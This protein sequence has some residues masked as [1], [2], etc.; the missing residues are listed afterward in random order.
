MLRAIIFF[1]ITITTGCSVQPI[2]T[3]PPSCGSID[4]GNQSI[5]RFP[6]GE[7]L[8]LPS[9]ADPA[10]PPLQWT[11]PEATAGLLFAD[12]PRFIAQTTDPVVLT[13]RTTGTAITVTPIEPANIPFLNLMYMPSRSMALVNDEVW[14]ANAFSPTIGRVEL[15][16]GEALESIPV[17]PWPTSIDVDPSLE[18]AIVTHAAN[19]TLGIIDTN[20]KQ[21]INS[22][23]V[24][25][26]PGTV[27]V[28]PATSIAYV[29]LETE[30]A[31]A[32]VDL[33]D[34]AVTHRMDAVP[35]PRAMA[36]SA[37]GSTLFVAGHRTGRPDRYPYAEDEE[38]QTD[39]QAI[40][41]AT[42]D[43][44]WTV[45]EAGNIITDLVADEER[46][47]L[48]VSTTV[49]FPERGLVTLDD[50]PFEAHVQAYDIDT[51]EWLHSTVLGPASEGEGYVLGPQALAL[52]GDS[53]WV[54]A[55]DSGLVVELD[56]NALAER[57]RTPISGGPRALLATEDGL[58][59]HA[60]QAMHMYRLSDREITA[61]AAT[62]V[63]PRPPAMA[64]GHLHFI[65]PGNTYGQNFS[66]NSCHYDGRGDTE[67]WRAGP[68]ETWEQSRP[69]MW[70][71]GTAPL[72][73][74]AYV[75]DTRTF[76]VTG[77]TSI[78]S[79]WPTTEMTEELTAFLSSMVPPPKANGWTERDG[80]LSAE[81]KLGQNLFNGKAGC[82]GCHSGA[83]T[84]SNQ[85]FEDGITEGRVSTPVLV[86]AYRH[87]SW[88]KD[89]SARTLED[90]TR[91]AAEWS[92]V[93]N[94]TDSEVEALVRYL[95]E[96]TDRDFFL[97]R[98]E[99]D[100]ERQWVGTEDPIRLTFN[101][102]VW[103]GD[104]AHR[105]FAV[106]DESGSSIPVEVAFNGR[107]V[108]LTPLNPL[109]ADHTYRTVV[110][111]Q[112]ES[113]DQRVLQ[114]PISIDFTTARKPELTFDGEYVMAVDMPAF[115]IENGRF[116]P[117]ITVVA[118]NP[119]KAFQT[120]S[121]SALSF[122]VG[123]ELVWETSAVIAADEFE[124]PPVPVKAGN[125][126]AQGSSVSGTA[127]DLDGDGVIDY[128]SG[129]FIVSGPGF[130]LEDVTWTIE[131]KREIPDCQPG[132]E[133]AV[134]V[135]V[136]MEDEDLVIDWEGDAGALGLYVTTY[137][138]TLPMGPGTSVS[139]GEAY[140]AI[141]T[142]EFPTG[143]SA[144]V[145]YGELPDGA[146]DD[147]ELNGIPFGGVE[148]AEGNCY[149]F[150][151][152]TDTFQIGSYTVEL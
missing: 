140:W 89:G 138:A 124:I 73:W 81:A 20:T 104:E 96:L 150:S 12:D 117:D 5:D 99:P 40:N 42:G 106:L 143:F 69:L 13:E 102:P 70:L 25:D 11:L 26:E 51:G 109:N 92:G 146:T 75:N 49:T 120:R 60:A 8:W 74:G 98:H 47:I 78:I 53:L 27:L 43:T 144:P 108:E 56:L 100:A 95:R 82:N 116:N 52:V 57:S 126:V 87:N 137:G 141:S 101:Q 38:G 97:L 17:G 48:W 80:Q 118:P 129:E 58:W 135:S 33:N 122:D 114:E 7:V 59:I 76:G 63:D 123:D 149:Q 22:I 32:V 151:V 61:M 94:L 10:C 91:A 139:D 14:V 112:L 16:T 55:Q 103:T 23:W 128:A 85:T 90:A 110:N 67:V 19:D 65:Q 88:L 35:N 111:E 44:L 84:T 125:S 64:A 152:I 127:L 21:M 72:G 83:L 54:A 77:F 113:F 107:V 134:A 145:V 66:C 121:G 31:V 68:F 133:G 132:A 46:S 142:T 28:D 6:I 71:D 93:T 39:I 2:A 50:P 15:D 86:G 119:F 37:N 105:L 62:A 136:S 30:S 4:L 148:L 115:D 9:I 1:T 24:G 3:D 34:Q 79:V 131:P 29:S 147:H 18:L 36:L 45:E 130:H 41:T